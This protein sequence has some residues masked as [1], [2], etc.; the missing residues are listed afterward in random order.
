METE[1]SHNPTV[2][3]WRA[4][5][6]LPA[7]LVVVDAVAT[8][9]VVG[10][11]R[12]CGSDCSG[13]FLSLLVAPTLR[14]FDVVGLGDPDARHTLLSVAAAF[15]FVLAATVLFWWLVA[16]VSDGVV[17]DGGVLQRRLLVAVAA[18]ALL[19]AVRLAVSLADALA[20]LSG[21][22]LAEAAI[23]TVIAYGA[24]T[25]IVTRRRRSLETPTVG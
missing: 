17:R 6:V 1:R 12:R 9:A 14:P 24:A 5:V 7:L 10:E 2:R 8:L 20:G 25:S 19:A 13:G 3:P 23:W 4:V 15:V 16:Q 21:G 22:L 11:G 18:L